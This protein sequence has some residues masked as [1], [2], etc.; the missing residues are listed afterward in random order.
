MP[1]RAFFSLK[2]D[3]AELKPNAIQWIPPKRGKPN[4]NPRLTLSGKWLSELRFT[5]GSSIT[6][7]RQAG[8]LVIRLAE[9][10]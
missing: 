9:N 6:L 5:V 4:P 7:T 8:Q 3:K 1:R 10:E 2:R